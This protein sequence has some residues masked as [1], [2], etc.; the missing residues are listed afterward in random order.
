MPLVI[1]FLGHQQWLQ[2]LCKLI[3]TASTV[4]MSTVDL[5][6]HVSIGS[7]IDLH[8]SLYSHGKWLCCWD[9]LIRLPENGSCYYLCNTLKAMLLFS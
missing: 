9:G 7:S 1:A 8:R 4:T 5:C 2:L 3:E 6:C